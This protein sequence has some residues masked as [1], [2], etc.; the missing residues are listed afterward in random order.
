[1]HVDY[2]IVGQGICGSML[3]WYLH[4][5]GKTFMVIDEPQPNTAS[6]VAAGLINPVTG[7][8]YSYSWMIE[9]IMPFAV[10]AYEELE[11][12]FDEKL[13]YK[14]HIIDFFPNPDARINFLNRL[15]E[16]D[17]FLHS[18]PDQNHFNQYF[19]YDFGCGEISPSYTVDLGLL[20]SLWRQQ[21]QRLAYLREE[22]FE[23][24]A[25]AYEE[26]S[27]RYLGITAKKIFFCE[28]AAAIS[29]QWFS[30][31]P[32]ARNKGEAIIINCPD[33]TN[34]HICKKGL[35]LVPLPGPG[36]FWVG[37][38]Y[39]WEFEDDL[40]SQQFHRQ[41]TGLLD[42]WLKKTYRIVEHKAALRPAT[43]ERR[44]FVGLHPASPAI[45]ILNGMGTKGTSL[46]PF[47]AHQLVQHLVHGLPI[48]PEAD[49]R[50]FTR[51]LSK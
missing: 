20:L 47:F 40:P 35:L 28:G 46:A 13:V 24:A 25:L 45:G 36:F 26:E 39:L 44:P 2:L 3:S 1:M 10:S 16:N 27:I 19:H 15:N 7:R 34:E 9:T 42:E 6:K 49:V 41:V 32:F 18:Y 23:Q 14:K 50:R 33:L 30:L 4:K 29:N 21:L 51:I 17:T 22:P 8:R 38:N 12:Y 37:S 11:T 31:L 43:L 5:E 48:T